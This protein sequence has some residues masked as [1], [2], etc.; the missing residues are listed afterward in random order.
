MKADHNGHGGSYGGEDPQGPSD[1]SRLKSAPANFEASDVELRG[2]IV[3]LI[4]LTVM[5]V[6][7]YVLMLLMFNLLNTREGAR[8]AEPSQMALKEKDRL[9]PEPRLQAAPGFAQQLGKEVGAKESEVSNERDKPKD[10][11]WELGQLQKRWDEDLEQGPKD[12]NGNRVGISIAL[13]KQQALSGNV[14]PAR[15]APAQQP[16]VVE[17]EDYAIEMPTAASSGRLTEKRKQ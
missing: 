11:T 1:S 3:F 8:E 4:G 5:T 10:R 13:A 15:A 2:I 16:Q 6:V 17:A 14:L 12:Q 9:P 7:V